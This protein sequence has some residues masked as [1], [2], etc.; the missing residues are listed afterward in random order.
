MVL[1]KLL[2][3]FID[4]HCNVEA[5]SDEDRFSIEYQFMAGAVSCYKYLDELFDREPIKDYMI[6]FFNLSKEIDEYIDQLG[7]SGCDGKELNPVGFMRP[8]EN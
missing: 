6:K 8:E 5:L 2:D 7:K 3:G 4:A 1:K